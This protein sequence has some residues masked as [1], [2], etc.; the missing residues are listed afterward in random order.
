MKTNE[1]LST[2]IRATLIGV[3]LLAA[4][5]A[6][7]PTPEASDSAKQ[8]WDQART[9]DQLDHLRERAVLVQTDR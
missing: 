2:G 5:C 7:S 9:A 6:K 4:A 3:L 8:G 1:V